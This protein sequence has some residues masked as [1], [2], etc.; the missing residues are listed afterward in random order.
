MYTAA[1]INY[2]KYL[3]YKIILYNY[4]T[5][6]MSERKMHLKIRN[7]LPAKINDN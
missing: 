5:V 4:K 6:Y 2:A 7:Q 1:Y 3:C